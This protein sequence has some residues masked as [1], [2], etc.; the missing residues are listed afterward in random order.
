MDEERCYWFDGV[1]KGRGGSSGL[2]S[3]DSGCF[4]WK[5]ERDRRREWLLFCFLRDSPRDGK[6][7]TCI[8][9]MEDLRDGR[10]QLCARLGKRNQD[11]CLVI[12]TVWRRKRAR[13]RWIGEMKVARDAALPASFHA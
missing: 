7:I 10:L 11:V 5:K 3:R 1:E 9:W 12:D 6:A 4:C 8:W 2:H 13:M